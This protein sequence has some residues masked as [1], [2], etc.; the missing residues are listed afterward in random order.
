M[1]DITPLDLPSFDSIYCRCQDTK[2]R[3][4]VA[5]IC[6]K[7]ATYNILILGLLTKYCQKD[8]L[9]F[10]K[11][12]L[13]YQSSKWDNNF[14]RLIGIYDYNGKFLYILCRHKLKSP[15]RHKFLTAEEYFSTASLIYLRKF[16][17]E[18]CCRY[19]ILQ[20]TFFFLGKAISIRN[21]W[22]D[23]FEVAS[24]VM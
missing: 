18:L 2:L 20:I 24:R 13:V 19:T 8:W 3:K 7:V 16:S 9:K 14:V 10:C 22:K 5:K 4:V 23:S 1:R 6:N 21:A 15:S 12:V 17:G 11:H